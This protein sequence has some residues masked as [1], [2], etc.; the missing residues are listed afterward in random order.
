M[1]QNFSLAAV[2]RKEF[3]SKYLKEIVLGYIG[4]VQDK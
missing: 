3:Y 1:P 4:E 2:V